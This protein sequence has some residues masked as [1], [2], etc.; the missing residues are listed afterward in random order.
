MP[1]CRKICQKSFFFNLKHK[2]KKPPVLHRQIL[3]FCACSFLH[4]GGAVCLENLR[5]L[6]LHSGGSWCPAVS[7]LVIPTIIVDH[8]SSNFV[9]QKKNCTNFLLAFCAKFLIKI[10]LSLIFFILKQHADE[11]TDP[12]SPS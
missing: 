9:H 6:C 11:I 3:M 10:V 5:G 4:S 12:P 2:F 8:L 7:S 1:L